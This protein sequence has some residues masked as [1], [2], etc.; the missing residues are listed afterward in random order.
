MKNN[1]SAANSPIRSSFSVCLKASDFTPTFHGLPLYSRRTVQMFTMRIFF[2][3]FAFKVPRD[4]D[5]LAGPVIGLNV[6]RFAILSIIAIYLKKKSFR[7]EGIYIYL[8]NKSGTSEFP[9][10][11]SSFSLF[12]FWF[13]FLRGRKKKA[14]TSLLLDTQQKD[15][16]SPFPLG[17]FYFLFAFLFPFDKHAE[18]ARRLFSSRTRL[19]YV[20]IDRKTTVKIIFFEKCLEGEMPRH[21]IACELIKLWA[22]KFWSLSNKM[23][24]DLSV[25]F[26]LKTPSASANGF[27][28][29]FRPSVRPLLL[30]VPRGVLI[31]VWMDAFYKADSWRRGKTKMLCRPQNIIK[32]GQPS[33]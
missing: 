31:R 15:S 6:C 23:A 32:P 21:S 14:N 17:I 9:R 26:F 24:N 20:D 30:S 4:T 2:L 13:P 33:V 3:L 28:L 16:A 27:T 10:R 22:L 7:S 18:S 29:I 11:V 12:W 1:T 5:A 8:K 19:L 25:F